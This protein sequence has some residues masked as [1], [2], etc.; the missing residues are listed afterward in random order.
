MC[1]IHSQSDLDICLL[2]H[3]NIVGHI[4]NLVR[5][6]MRV[7]KKVH[8][9]LSIWHLVLSCGVRLINYV[10]FFFCCPLVYFADTADQNCSPNSIADSRAADSVHIVDNIP[11]SLCSCPMVFIWD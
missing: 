10:S 4:T 3:I 2:I 11:S 6:W 9:H 5:R 1:R 8:F 7:E